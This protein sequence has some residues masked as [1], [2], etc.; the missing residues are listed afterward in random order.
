MDNN[1]SITDR[2]AN[3][4]NNNQNPTPERQGTP[5]RPPYSPVTPVLAQL[6]PIPGGATI[7][8]PPAIEDTAAAA[9][10][11]GVTTSNPPVT[12]NPAKYNEPVN[13]Q[14]VMPPPQQSQQPQQQQQPLYPPPHPIRP[15]PSPVPI[16]ESDNADIIALR[17]AISLLQFQKQKALNDI[18][19]LDEMKRA[20]AA[21]PEAFSRELLAGNLTQPDNQFIDTDI[22][23]KDD[24]DDDSD[25]EEVEETKSKFGK[26]PKPQN[27]VRMPPINWAKYHIVGEPLDKMHEEQ[28]NRPF[29]GAPR[30]DPNQRAPEHFIAA[31]YRPLTD[32]V[33]SPAKGRG[34]KERN[35]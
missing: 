9:T 13:P 12:K 6:A 14:A 34:K 29:A 10:T 22:T 20:A 35:T 1:N 15:Q 18:K 4:N 16:S 32:R 25:A 27:V 24:D 11:M 5:E 21:D 33:K 2:S 8:P 19:A 28:R 7:V 31:P 30:Q 23:M 26:I 17:S 3:D